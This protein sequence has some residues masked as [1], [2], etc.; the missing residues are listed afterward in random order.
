MLAPAGGG[1]TAL[2][3]GL[4]QAVV[5]GRVPEYLKNAQVIDTRHVCDGRREQIAPVSFRHVL[6]QSVKDW[7]N[8]TIILN[9]HVTSCLLMRFI[10]SC[11]PLQDRPRLACL[12]S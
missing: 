8:A 7:P 5:A 1:K 9:F 6:F 4:A 11:Q 10:L 12:R 2:V 3:A